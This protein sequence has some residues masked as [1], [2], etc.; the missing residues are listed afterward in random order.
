[1]LKVLRASCVLVRIRGPEE[2]Y[3]RVRSGPL[4]YYISKP[5]MARGFHS[6]VS[7]FHVVE[8]CVD[9]LRV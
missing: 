9:G 2:F 5:H 7:R 4:R 1:M 3:S 6:V 8:F